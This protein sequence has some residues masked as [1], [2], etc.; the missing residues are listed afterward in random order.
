MAKQPPA[1][2]LPLHRDASLEKA[3]VGHRKHVALHSKKKA[4]QPS[5]A[6]LL[7][8]NLMQFNKA[9]QHQTQT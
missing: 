6:A 2:D 4:Q 8:A 1:M 9:L 5:V 3:A 7:E